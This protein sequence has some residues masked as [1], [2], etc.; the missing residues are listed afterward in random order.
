MIVRRPQAAS[1]GRHASVA[2]V[3]RHPGGCESRAVRGRKPASRPGRPG[4]ARA[5]RGQPMSGGAHA[6]E[7]AA[8]AAQYLLLGGF[9]AVAAGI[10][11]QGLT[12]FARENMGL[13]G[14]WPYLLFLAL[15]GAAGVCAVLLT[16]RAA[17]AESGLAPRLAVWGLVA[18]SASFNWTH[19]PHRPGAPEAFGLMPV[20]AAVLFEFTLRELRQRAAGRADRQMAALRWLYP[21]ERFRVQRLLAADER[22]SAQQATRRVRTGQAA[23]RLYQLRRALHARDQAP[24]PGALAD[25][26]ARIAERRAHAALI[27]AGFSDPAVAADV[28]RQVQVLTRTAYLAR[29]DYTTAE[30]ARDAIASLITAGPPPGP[31]SPALPP[32]IPGGA[33]RSLPPTAAG[34][35]APGLP[36]Q[37]QPGPAPAQETEQETEPAD[38]RQA[39]G[40]Q[41]ADLD[42]E[43]IA[44]AAGILAEARRHRE[45]LSQKALGRRLRRDGYRVA[46]DSLRGLLAAASGQIGASSPPEPGKAPGGPA[47]PERLVNGS[48]TPLASLAARTRARV[49]PRRAA[50][51][52]VTTPRPAAP[53]PAR[54]DERQQKLA[55]LRARLHEDAQALRT[56]GDWAARLRLAALMPGE[57]FANILLISSQRPGA[58]MVRDYRQWTAAGRQVRRHEKGIE[59]F[60]IPPRPAPGRPQD[61]DERDD[62]EP[63]PTWRDADRVGY[64]WDLSQT[65]GQPVTVAAGLPPPGPGPG[66]PVGCAVLAGPPRRIRSRTRRRRTSRRHHLLGRPPHP[67]PSRPDRRASQLGTGAPARPHPAAQHTRRSPARGDHHLLHGSAQGR[68]RLHRLHHL[69]PARRHRQRPA[70]LPGKLAGTDPRAQPAATILAAGHRIT[71]AAASIIRHTD[72]ILHGDDPAPVPAPRQQPAA[73][74]TAHTHTQSRQDDDASRRATTTPARRPAAPRPPAGTSPRTL[75]VLRDAETYYTGQ[76]AG[77]WAPGYLTSRG[78]TEATAR[79]WH[80]GYAPAGW[81]TL[82]DHLRSLGHDD[83]EIQAAGLAKPSSRGTLIDIFRDRIVLPVHDADG[84]PAGF[85][86]R[87]HPRAGPDVPKYLNSPE[88]A[89]YKKGSLL[90]GLHH[91]R[92]ALAREATPVIVEGP[93]DAIAVTT[94][95]PGRLAG[96]A[97]CGTALTSQQAALISQAADLDRT[98]ILVAFDSDPAG[99]RATLR[100]YGILLP[101]TPKLQTA[102]LDGKDPAEILQHHG[103]DALRGILRDRREPLSAVLIDARIESWESTAGR[104]GG[105]YLAM[106]NV[107]VLIADLLPDETPGRSAASPQAGNSRRR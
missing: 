11:A 13:T 56:P 44:A 8:S 50:G 70:C 22:I 86:G 4:G 23:R 72:R 87:A 97:P 40:G 37:P 47:A 53:D 100:A 30:P 29:L 73:P 41:D 101:L 57:D 71:T 68:S 39:D 69:R 25:R 20:V 61:R 92:P 59:T 84:M 16:R 105:P 103:P 43:I 33:P 12:G 96:L 21:V 36:G 104:P 63:P 31:A 81:S 102:L 62:D 1:T 85:I 99:R 54:E 93:F 32:A 64:V 49:R 48:Y 83:R 51:S 6:R 88:T 5:V 45:R 38:G 28:L 79:D 94:A 95:D 35:A 26:H 80:I 65:T 67:A 10:S 55:A 24:R 60:R 107:A 66:R 42:G 106:L 46:N 78:L 17:R 14:P 27:R 18:A 7:T 34:P 9:T 52:P 3:R 2:S 75:A 90:F 98:G 76:L 15:D 82:T 89:A 91:A 77:S 74:A 58:T 19:A